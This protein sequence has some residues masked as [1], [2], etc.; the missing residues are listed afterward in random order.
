V[1]PWCQNVCMKHCR[2][3]TLL[4][5]SV[6]PSILAL[7]LAI[8][9]PA[10][11]SPA[12]QTEGANIQ[13]NKLTAA[14]EPDAYQIYSILLRTEMSPHWKIAEWAINR[15]TQTFPN[16]GGRHSVRECLNVAR[17]QEAVYLRLIDNYIAKNNNKLVLES[18][19]ELPRYELVDIGRASGGANR[20]AASV[21]FDVSA[22]GFNN[23]RT[24]AL[25]YVGHHCGSLCGGGRY[26][27]LA[28]K[29]DKW[30]VDREYRGMSC[31]WAS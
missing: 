10:Y 17:D 25:V 20:S 31:L 26:H 24:R 15:Q 11:Q 19:F 2:I 14:E 8:R 22:I 3:V 18:K 21:I 6:L 28:K 1:F 23:D 9:I 4:R 13:E 30:E 7:P 5:M 29:D 27:L 16:I 12:Q